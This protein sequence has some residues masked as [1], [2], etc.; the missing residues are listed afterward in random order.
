MP[1]KWLGNAEE[2]IRKAKI[3]TSSKERDEDFLIHVD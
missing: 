2:W 3:Q 1:D